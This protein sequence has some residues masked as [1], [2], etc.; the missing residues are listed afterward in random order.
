MAQRSEVTEIAAGSAT[1]IKD[2]LRSVAFDRIE[3]RPVILTDI[4]VTRAIPESLGELIIKC[5]R[6]LREA[7]D[8]AL[9]H[10]FGR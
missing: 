7:P 10:I 1:K 4:V 2:G 5:D 8:P 6:R 9:G 3:E